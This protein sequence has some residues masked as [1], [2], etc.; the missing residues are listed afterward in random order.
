[1]R[2]LEDYIRALQPTEEDK[3]IL[4]Y[5]SKYKLW[6]HGDY[7]GTATWTHDRLVGDSFQ[8][9]V[10]V[11]GTLLQFVYVADRYE[12]VIDTRKQKSTNL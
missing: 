4:F 11:D 9:R 10:I 7:I 5:G 2:K 6:L 3:A 1:M 8:N 12:L